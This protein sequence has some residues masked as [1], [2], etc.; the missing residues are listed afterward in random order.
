M[1]RHICVFHAIE[2]ALTFVYDNA[3][4]KEVSFSFDLGTVNDSNAKD[5]RPDVSVAHIVGG[6]I[7]MPTMEDVQERYDGDED[8]LQFQLNRLISQYTARA[9]IKIIHRCGVLLG[10]FKRVTARKEADIIGVEST[11]LLVGDDAENMSS[12]K[13]DSHSNWEKELQ[14]N[15]NE[16]IQ[17][18][19]RYCAIHFLV[20]PFAS[21]IIALASAGPFWQWTTI[22]SEQV[23]SFDWLTGLLVQSEEN[24]QLQVDFVTLFQFKVANQQLSLEYFVLATPEFDAQI[25]EIRNT[26]FDFIND[27]HPQY[28]PFP[29]DFDFT[30][31][32]DE[33]KSKILP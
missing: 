11:D 10:E 13:E 9:G 4:I 1:V 12:T 17:D 15:L 30:L 32:P 16:A 18:T 24:D 23:P 26:M 28:P 22:K 21:E 5:S 14:V 7:R 2:D 33:P 6:T 19:M 20:H 29:A 3:A 8:E 31:L 25:N 27:S